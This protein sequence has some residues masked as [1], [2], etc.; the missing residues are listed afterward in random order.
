MSTVLRKF[1]FSDSPLRWE[2]DVKGERVC[3]LA[4]LLEKFYDEWQW[5]RKFLGWHRDDGKT[6]TEQMMSPNRIIVPCRKS[7]YIEIEQRYNEVFGP[8]NA[9][10]LYRSWQVEGDVLW[11]GIVQVNC[12]WTSDDR[13]KTEITAQVNRKAFYQSE[14]TAAVIVTL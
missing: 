4:Q 9:R 8:H 2:F 5:D 13:M 10:L 7:F 11:V 3:S 14:Q 1:R 6:K 12:M